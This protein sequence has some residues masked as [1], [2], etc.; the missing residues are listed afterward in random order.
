MLGD[1]DMVRRRRE[2]CLN[3]GNS[4]CDGLE[5]DKGSFGVGRSF[6][7]LWGKVLGVGVEF[8]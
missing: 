8:G 1:E 5:V 3:R 7:W 6:G 2:E 4:T